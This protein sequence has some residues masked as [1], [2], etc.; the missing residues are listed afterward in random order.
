GHATA[1]FPA[2]DQVLAHGDD[3]YNGL[4]LNTPTPLVLDSYARWQTEVLAYPPGG[5]TAAYNSQ[6]N[7]KQEARLH[8]S[9]YLM[10]QYR[11]GGGVDVRVVAV[12]AAGHRAADHEHR[13]L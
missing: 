12:D 1:L 11:S 13:A 10:E 2:T 5:A 6:T 9:A 3:V 8:P 4:L 7:D